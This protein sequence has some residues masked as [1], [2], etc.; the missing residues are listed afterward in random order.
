VVQGFPSP[1]PA[2]AANILHRGPA[3]VTQTG[4]TQAVNPDL[5]WKILKVESIFHILGRKR[6]FL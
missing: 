5:C 1:L 2:A 3:K 4:G 6:G